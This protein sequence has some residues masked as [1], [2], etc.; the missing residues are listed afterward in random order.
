[1]YYTQVGPKPINARLAAADYA[2]CFILVSAL[3]IV[4]FLLYGKY[5]RLYLQTVL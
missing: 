3:F 1:M 2:K 4:V 5:S